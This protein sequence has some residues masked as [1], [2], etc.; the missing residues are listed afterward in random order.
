MRTHQ[1]FHT[2]SFR[3]RRS[4]SRHA[5][6]SDSLNA[7][8]LP[9]ARPARKILHLANTDAAGPDEQNATGVPLGNEL[10]RSRWTAQ[11]SDGLEYTDRDERHQWAE[12]QSLLFLRADAKLQLRNAPRSVSRS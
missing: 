9:D 8:S 12:I 4:G 5:S 6:Q 3:D 7:A 2:F 10:V 11:D 1:E